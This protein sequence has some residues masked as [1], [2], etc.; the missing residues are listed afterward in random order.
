[1]PAGG[2]GAG[3]SAP[4]VIL[5]CIYAA[6]IVAFAAVVREQMVVGD[7][8]V[9][10]MAAAFAPV[11]P[12]AAPPAELI[13]GTFPAGGAG[14][15]LQT[16]GAPV[17]PAPPLSLLLAAIR[18]VESAGDDFAVGDGGRSHGPYQIGRLYWIDAWGDDSGWPCYCPALSAETVVRYWMRWCSEALESGDWETLARVHNGGPRGASKAATLPYWAKVQDAMKEGAK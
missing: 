18:Q 15:A 9:A 10:G 14:D 17:V 2:G 13:A 16:E 12:A 3:M 6:F 5:L 7:C 1:M 4:K 11:S 8:A